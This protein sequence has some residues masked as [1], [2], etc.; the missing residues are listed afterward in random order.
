MRM[1]PEHLLCNRLDNAAEIEESALLGDAGL[2]NNLKK[3]S[4]SSSLDCAGP[5]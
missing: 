3:Q 2:K 5:P 4:P 1:T